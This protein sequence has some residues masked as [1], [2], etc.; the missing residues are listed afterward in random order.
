MRYVLNLLPHVTMATLSPLRALTVT[1]LLLA[2]WEAQPPT[3]EAQP[4]EV[5]EL[6]K[7][8]VIGGEG[9]WDFLSID[10]LNRHLFIAHATQ[11]DV[12]DLDR[13]VVIAHIT[14][15]EGV[16]GIAIAPHERHGF[17][18]CGKSNSVLMFDLRTLDTTRRIAVGEKPDAIIYDQP[19]EHIFVM[20]AK[21]D[22][23]SVLDAQSGDLLATIKL[24]GA[25]EFAVADQHGHVFLN[26]EDKSEVL[27][28]DTKTNKITATWPLGK[29]EGPTGIAFEEETP[30]L[31]VG[32]ANQTLVILNAKTGGIMDTE[33]IGQGVDAVAFDWR[34]GLLFSS[35]GDGTLNIFSSPDQGWRTV[36]KQATMHTP[37]G[38]RTMAL[39]PKTHNVYLVTA[40]FGPT[41]AATPE[42]PHPRPAILPGTFALYTYAMTKAWKK[43]YEQR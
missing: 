35:N 30:A 39:D 38:A 24:P 19:S 26:L 4:K 7:K 16:H 31:F 27:K 20:N 22:D 12:Y 14:H 15:T 29:G 36:E 3:A 42:N 18:S 1:L 41:P 25:P 10:E 5:Y 32:C 37:R 8:T 23:V 6:L 40:E 33:M 34:T 11:V 9:G 13:D 2:A 28:I 21:S 17:I 43:T